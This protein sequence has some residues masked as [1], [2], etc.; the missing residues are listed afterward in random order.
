MPRRQMSGEM[1][2][3][4][5]RGQR[6]QKSPDNVDLQ[7]LPSS[8]Y[9]AMADKLTA[10]FYLAEAKRL[11]E[12]T[13]ITHEPAQRLLLLETASRFR[14]M[15]ARIEARNQ[16]ANAANNNSATNAKEA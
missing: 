1:M 13:L 4:S 7:T 5:G 3:V 12:L 11:L 6:S 8:I 14:E 2:L 16:A 15:A 9:C 10:R